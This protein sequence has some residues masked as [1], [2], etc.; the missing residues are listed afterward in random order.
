MILGALAAGAV[1]VVLYPALVPAK[2]VYHQPCLSQLKQAALA[3]IMYAYDEDALPS[4]DRWVDQTFPYAKSWD[5]FHCPLA[6]GQWGYAFN[7]GLEG[8]NVEKMVSAEKAP[9]VYDSVNP[10]KNASDLFKS[11]P[12][13]PRHRMNNVGYADGHVKAL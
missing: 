10:V 4:R 6:V 11:L 1:F 9:M 8:K 5:V 3:Q 12:A 13:T 7:G 2:V